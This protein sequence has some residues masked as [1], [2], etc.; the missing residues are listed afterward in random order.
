MIWLATLSIGLSFSSPIL[1]VDIPPP[2]GET[3]VAPD[4]KL[5]LLYHAVGADQG[6]ADRRAGRRARRQ[7][8]FLRHSLR[9]G[10]AG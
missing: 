9:Q 1:A 5:E 4:A 8:L 7:H 10:Q 3:I 2:T 6:R